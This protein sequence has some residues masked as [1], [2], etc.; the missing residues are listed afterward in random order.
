MTIVTHNS[1]S[2]SQPTVQSSVIPTIE[3]L[4]SDHPPFLSLIV[5]AYNE[6]QRLLASLRQ[7]KEYLQRQPYSSEV[8]VVDDGSVDGTAAVVEAFMS[9]YNSLRL[10]RAVHGGK[11]H[12]CK[13]GVFHSRGQWLFLCDADLSMPIAE[14]SS[15]VPLFT[16]H[17]PILIASREL[18]ASQRHGEPWHRHVMGRVFNAL[19]QILAV[20]GIQD[21]Q[22]G[23][24]CF[25]A[26][27]ARDIFRVQRISGWGFD[28]E[29]L[30]VA[31]KR[32]YDIIEVPINWY[33][34]SHSKVH[35]VR[36]T[37]HMFREVWQVR[38]NDWHRCYEASASSPDAN[39]LPDQCRLEQSYRTQPYSVEETLRAECADATVPPKE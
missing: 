38:W 1:Y 32:G 23:F 2:V 30:F 37:I 33:Y 25:R 11:G 10:V 12:A 19:V 13:Q 15:F 8:I 20:R 4:S 18:P 35:P 24:K 21:T 3:P 22:C 34:R 26:D 6:E 7:I 31:R 16:R 9:E 5:P 17:A 28:V 29:V 36:D 14:L 39:A 27:V